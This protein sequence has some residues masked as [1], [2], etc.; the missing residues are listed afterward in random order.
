MPRIRAVLR[1]TRS[2]LGRR[3]RVVLR[4]PRAARRAVS[5]VRRALAPLASASWP[6]LTS[7]ATVTIAG[8]LLGFA[9]IVAMVAGVWLGWP[10]LYD[11][12]APQTAGERKDVVLIV[13]QVIGVTGILFG[14]IFT[15]QRL[16]AAERTIQVAQEGQITE[17]FTRAIG[18]LG[19]PKLEVRLGGIYALER[20]AGDSPRDHWTIV[21]VLTAYVREN[22]PWKGDSEPA[23][24]ADAPAPAANVALPPAVSTVRP[25]TDI[26]AILMVLG[27]RPER[28]RTEERRNNLAL[29]LGGTDLR[30]AQLIRARLERADLLAAHLEGA[31]LAGA[32]LEG[33]FLWGAHLEGADLR[34]T[35]LEGAILTTAHLEGADL[36]D[37]HL[38]GAGLWDAHLEGATLWDAHL[39]EANLSR[40]HLDGA[41]LEGVDLSGALGLTRQQL[42]SAITDEN[43]LLPD[44]LRDQGG[45]P[46]STP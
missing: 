3:W 40:A 33:A 23:T 2:F 31:I 19:E 44:Y 6:V 28:A 18:Q 7:R 25:R 9:A 45:A 24:A 5:A 17:R 16:R 38:E 34:A 27:R 35:H 42:A 46:P 4:T 26:Q 13:V 37:A 43:T 11:Y 36:W 30:G 41:H 39:E 1:A 22:A 29:D 12:L 21:E 14:L 20:I 15:Y 8:L 10:H 32:H